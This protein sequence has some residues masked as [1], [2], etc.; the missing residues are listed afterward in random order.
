LVRFILALRAE[1]RFGTPPAISLGSAL[2][3]DVVLLAGILI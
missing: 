3:D 2:L 1:L